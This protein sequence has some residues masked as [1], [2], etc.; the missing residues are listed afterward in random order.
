MLSLCLLAISLPFVTQLDGGNAAL[1]DLPGIAVLAEETS[2]DVQVYGVD[3]AW[4]DSIAARS[5]A[6]SGV[7]LLTRSDAAM[8]RRQPILAIRLESVRITDSHTFAWH[9]AVTAHQKT[10]T[11]AAPPDTVLNATWAATGAIGV[12]SGTKLKA[13]VRETLESKLGEFAEAWKSQK[14]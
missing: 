11:M 9:L 14:H 10:I 4:I 12:T 5:L 6:K 2:P 7:G 8:T 1:K 3:A 13:S